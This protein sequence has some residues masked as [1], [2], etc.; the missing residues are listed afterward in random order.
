MALYE[1][2]SPCISPPN[3]E[4]TAGPGNIP[5]DRL[6]Q[7]SKYRDSFDPDQPQRYPEDLPSAQV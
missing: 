2:F 6:P 1:H 3:S 5:K 4:N 7:F